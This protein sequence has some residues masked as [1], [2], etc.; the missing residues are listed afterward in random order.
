MKDVLR[1]LGM[2][3]QALRGQGNGQEKRQAA[4]DLFHEV[5]EAEAQ[6]AR[7]V[8]PEL[9]AALETAIGECIDAGMA[10]DKVV[11]EIKHSQSR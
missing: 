9:H 6:I 2:F 5:L 8:S 3:V 11:T 4:I 7:P 1:F 10:L